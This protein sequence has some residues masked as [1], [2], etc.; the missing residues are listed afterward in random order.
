MVWADKALELFPEHPELL[1]VKAVACLR[2]A[3][4]EKAIAYSDNSISK[5]NVTPRVWLARAEVVLGRKSSV[6]DNCI[7]KAIGSAGNITPIIKLEAARLLRKK[8]DYSAAIRYLN[9]VVKVFP[10]SAM[11]WCEIGCCQAKLGLSGAKAS[12]EQSLRL[13]PDLEAA[14]T[15]LKSVDKKGF[16]RK[17]F[18][19]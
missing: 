19:W 15:A 11:V 7:S 16:F 10:Q 5:E 6:A 4:A 18:N 13:R 14:K 2:D 12:L 3:K 9:D 8:G 1:A 17:L